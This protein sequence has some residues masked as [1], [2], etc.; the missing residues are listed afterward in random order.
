MSSKVISQMAGTVL[1]INVQVGD[2]IK[3]G[4]EVAIL[5]SMKMEV[6]VV[7]ACEGKVVSVLKAKGDFVNEGDVVIE[8]T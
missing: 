7:S 8:L 1:E 4:Q 2:T 6:P 5:E 3:K